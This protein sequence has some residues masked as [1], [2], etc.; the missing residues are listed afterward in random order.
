M[1]GQTVAGHPERMKV[2]SREETAIDPETDYVEFVLG[3]CWGVSLA[4]I[5]LQGHLS[6]L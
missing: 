3:L 4:L 1:H 5:I 2:H 6:L